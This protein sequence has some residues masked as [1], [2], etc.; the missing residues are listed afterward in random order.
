[1]EFLAFTT[2][3]WYAHEFCV[4]NPKLQLKILCESDKGPA[5]IEHGNSIACNFHICKKYIF[6]I[7]LLE[8]FIRNKFFN[9]VVNTLFIKQNENCYKEKESPNMQKL[10]DLHNPEKKI[11]EML[12]CQGNMAN[13]ND[14]AEKIK[15][16]RPTSSFIVEQSRQYS[17]I[18]TYEKISNHCGY[19]F[20]KRDMIFVEN[21]AINNS[22]IR[23]KTKINN[24][25]NSGNNFQIADI[26]GLK[27]LEELSGVRKISR[28]FKEEKKLNALKSPRNQIKREFEANEKNDLLD[29]NDVDN[30]VIKYFKNERN[31][32]AQTLNEN[33]QREKNTINKINIPKSPRLLNHSK[34][35]TRNNFSSKD[36]S[37]DKTYIFLM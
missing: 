37:P 3:T 12:K 4:K 17:N 15:I 28:E 26:K 23:Q 29:Q 30:H 27:F 18:K 2:S 16:K 34:Y 9:I 1:M 22:P 5:V 35:F 31:K 33:F 7:K 6:T 20:N 19:G 21:N 24:N 11:L 8:N 13:Y 25:E 32:L 14:E 36:L 10:K